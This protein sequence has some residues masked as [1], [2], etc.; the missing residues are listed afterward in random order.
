MALI[1]LYN[2]NQ[3]STPNQGAIT[4]GS[5]KLYQDTSAFDNITPPTPGTQK[6]NNQEIPADVPTKNL[7]AYD[8][9]TGIR[10]FKLPTGGVFSEDKNKNIIVGPHSTY[11]NIASKPGFERDDVIPVSLG[12]VNASP[13][14]IKLVPIDK[15]SKQDLV[16]QAN[17]AKVKAGVNPKSLIAETL[18]QKEQIA[19][20]PSLV[21]K[22]LDFTK[23]LFSPLVPNMQENQGTMKTLSELQIDPLTL[24]ANPKKAVLD[25]WNGIKDSVV[26]AGEDLR[27]VFTTPG[28]AGKVGA[29]AGT[30]ARTTGAVLSPMTALFS[31]A[32]DIPIAGTI[33]KLIALPFEYSG[34]VGTKVSNTIIDSLPI[35]QDIKDKLKPGIAELTGLAYQFA[36]GGATDITKD[37]MKELVTKFGAQD[38]QTIVDKAQEIAQNR[39]Q[40][41]QTAQPEQIKL[42]P[43]ETQPPAVGGPEKTIPGEA[44]QQPSETPVKPTAEQGLSPEPTKPSGLGKSIEQKAIEDKLT[45]GFKNVAGYDSSTIK[46]Q[47]AMVKDLLDSGVDNAR[48]IIRGSKPLPD[49]MRGS[50]LIVGME[51]FIKEH[52]ELNKNGELLYELANSPLVSK[53]SQAGSEL[54]LMQN[55]LQDSATARLQDIKNARDAQVKDLPKKK[56][57]QLKNLTDETNK[58][59]LSKED[60]SWNKFLDNIVC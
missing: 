7:V 33:S 28:I 41:Q 51:E 54:G 23:S 26:S 39:I 16:E 29:A 48:D 13:D 34:E 19:N 40:N 6:W 1:R 24:K 5:I 50:S 57:A 59:N 55:R 17:A 43:E 9:A 52:P 10:T 14:N 30:V 37:K 4:T 31:A 35:S 3:G 25:Y 18:S 2:D 12:G 45:T 11:G 8:N 22:T 21:Q 36:L 27:S 38:A 49:R 32:N 42:Y 58:I 56:T 46:E 47:S 44:L 15:A 53:V 20:A 60:L